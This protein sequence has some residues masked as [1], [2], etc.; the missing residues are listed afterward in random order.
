MLTKLI[1]KYYCLICEEDVEVCNRKDFDIFFGIY[2]AILVILICIT[3]IFD[4]FNFSII[5]YLPL[6]ICFL[7]VHILLILLAIK[8]LHDL[9]LN[10]FFIFIPFIAIALLFFPSVENNKK[11]SK[12]SKT[13]MTEED[14]KEN[15]NLEKLIELLEK[16]KTKEK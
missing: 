7:I 16:E 14:K 13:E 3:A 11:Y 9:E 10:G 1:A 2:F 8:R 4:N 5:F 15:E 12:N 6:L